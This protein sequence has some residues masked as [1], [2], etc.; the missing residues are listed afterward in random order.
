MR[1]IN[2]QT[3]RAIRLVWL[4]FAVSALSVFGASDRD[5]IKDLNRRIEQVEE[6]LP[7]SVHYSKTETSGDETTI[8]QAWFNGAGDLIK[9]ATDHTAAGTRELTEYFAAKFASDEPMFILTR[10][11]TTQP[12][13]AIQVEEARQYFDNNAELVRDLRKT[14][15]FKAGESTDT[16]KVPNKPVDL[17]KKPKDN[18]DEVAKAKT[19]N[20][21]FDK[22]V[23]I[24]G[25]IKA[26][27]PPVSDPFANITGDSEKYRLIEDSVTP[28]GRYAIGL[29]LARDKIDW[30][31]FRDKDFDEDDH[32]I[33]T[34]EQEDLR[35][36]VVDLVHK[37]I[38][39][40]TG[41]DYF[42][43]KQRYNMRECLLVWSPDSKNFVETTVWKWGYNTCQ[44]GRIADGPKLVGVVDLGKYAEKA[45]QNFRKSRKLGSI[46]IFVKEITNDGTISLNLTDQ[47]S[48]GDR[49]GDVN[50]SADEKIRLR[51]KSGALQLETVSVRKAAEE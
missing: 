10:K 28:D 41:C 11:E 37:K 32:V 15:R 17:S 19:R 45:A 35:N 40:I 22:P 49:K 24:A 46:A 9:V 31:E 48:S 6:Q 27:G 18:R 29:G 1:S 47:E 13:G 2:K 16:V 21:F 30:E 25:I 33:Y 20:E 38:L 4:C 50:F 14:A 42:G 51:E 12:D 26:A 39:G 36:Y 7:R 34:A 5:D 23:Q 43:T 44:A 8:Q 3:L